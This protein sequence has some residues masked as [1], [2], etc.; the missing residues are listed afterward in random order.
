M[1]IA[2]ILNSFKRNSIHKINNKKQNKSQLITKKS[3]CLT[4]ILLIVF[5]TL[6]AFVPLLNL[7]N[8][9]YKDIS[10]PNRSEL[11]KSTHTQIIDYNPITPKVFVIKNPSS[12]ELIK[13]EHIVYLIYFNRISM[14]DFKITQEIEIPVKNKSFQELIELF[15]NDSILK[16]NPDKDNLGIPC[17]PTYC[18]K[19]QRLSDEEY[20]KNQDNVFLNSTY[21]GVKNKSGKKRSIEQ[22][23]KLKKGMLLRSDV[24]SLVGFADVAGRDQLNYTKSYEALYDID[25]TPGVNMVILSLELL[26]SKAENFPR[27]KLIKVYYANDKN[28]VLELEITK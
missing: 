19:P 24:K 26:A 14:T 4:A 17:L 10:E 7:T 22:F 8:T 11:I 20:R 2:K 16:S 28:E 3:I 12:D 23:K 15:K 25:D 21:F 13:K 1:N 6:T 9:I 18:T 5:S 27:E